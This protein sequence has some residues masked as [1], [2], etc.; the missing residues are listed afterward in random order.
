[1]TVERMQS[2]VADARQEI[3][4]MFDALGGAKGILDE[5]AA[6]LASRL[7]E[8]RPALEQRAGSCLSLEPS[9]A[10]F[11]IHGD[12]HLGQVLVT[13]DDVTI[14]DFE[15]EPR[16]PIKERRAKASPLR[17]VA[18]MLRSIDYAAEAAMRQQAAMPP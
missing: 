13:H 1:V 12:Y 9:G 15:G 3:E 6:E 4:R 5:E 16:R 17:D 7:E 2:W 18:G 10:V 11:R 14:I 8:L